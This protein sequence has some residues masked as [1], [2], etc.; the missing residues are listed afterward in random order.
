MKGHETRDGTG[1]KKGPNRQSCF[2]RVR[3]NVLCSCRGSCR[4]PQ[5]LPDS[6]SCSDERKPHREFDGK[7]TGNKKTGR[8]QCIREL[9]GWVEFRPPGRLH[10]PRV[11]R[12]PS[13]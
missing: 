10:L 5:I 6:L 1:A 8:T 3:A 4:E 11:S 13:P 12:P 2:S 7:L 9:L